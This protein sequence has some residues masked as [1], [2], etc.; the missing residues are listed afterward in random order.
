LEQNLIHTHVITGFLGTGKTTTLQ[1]LLKQ[2]PAHE[3][4][5][6]LLNEF[7]KTG[8]DSDLLNNDE[9]VVSQVAGGCLCC[10]TPLLFQTALNKI[11]RFEKPQ[12]ILIE[13]SGLGHPDK[14][15][16][17][18]KQDQYQNI[19]KIEAVLTLIDARNLND[20]RYREHD[21]YQRQLAVAD[22]F[23]A[24]KIEL[25]TDQELAEFE[26]LLDKY[27]RPGIQVN[28]GQVNLETL[29][30]T[31]H[32]KPRLV[33]NAISQE[34]NPFFTYTIALDANQLLSLPELLAYLMSL[35]LARVKAVVPT[36]DG[37][38][39]LNGVKQEITTELT[40][41]VTGNFRLEI[42]SAQEL[43]IDVITD[44]INAFTGKSH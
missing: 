44:T 40:K 18:L 7:G 43:D 4:W 36:K 42:I 39:L 23:V 12:R 26:K 35:E 22:I 5:V 2:K 15:V 32:N 1:Y 19:L 30:Q 41:L 21:I 10:A 17:L 11:I 37:T 16:E 13:P 25:A 3:K 34:N 27:Q 24:N 38:M 20:K 29:Q 14:I 6:V 8:L 28:Q 9:V 33:I 31:P